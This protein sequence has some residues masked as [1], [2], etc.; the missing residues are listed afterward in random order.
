MKNSNKVKRSYRAANSDGRENCMWVDIF[1][2]PRNSNRIWNS[3]ELEH[4]SN[5]KNS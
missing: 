1:I 2:M 3:K 5:A 4:P